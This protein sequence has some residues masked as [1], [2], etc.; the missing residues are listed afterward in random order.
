MGRG[1]LEVHLVDAKGLA[2]TDFLGESVKLPPPMFL[3]WP[4]I[5]ARSGTEIH[6]SSF[7][8]TCREDRPICDRAIPEP[9]AQEQH[10]PRFE[11]L[12]QL[13]DSESSVDE[14]EEH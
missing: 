2:G 14:D 13:S 5:C 7:T 11:V 4:R 6:R 8:S 1:L 9:G 12:P 3:V 10:R